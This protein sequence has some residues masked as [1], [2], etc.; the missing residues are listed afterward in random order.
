MK[1][2]SVYSEPTAVKLLYELL[3]QRTPETNI[4]HKE[5]PSW[6][7]HVRFVNKKP[8]DKWWLI[9]NRNGWAG[10]IYVTRLH[11]VGI[12]LF[13]EHQGKGVGSQALIKVM[14]LYP[15]GLLAN[16]NPRNDGSKRFFEK[17]GFKLIQETFWSDGLT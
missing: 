10:G 9:R 3:S 14:A 2:I 13:S 1:L 4:S 6:E 8:Y 17:H 15:D 5:M 7:E 11:E 16:I 12:Q